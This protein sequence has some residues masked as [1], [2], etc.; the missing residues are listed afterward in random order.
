MVGE[1]RGLNGY[2]D[3]VPKLQH[4]SERDS[5]VGQTTFAFHAADHVVQAWR[6]DHYAPT[7]GGSYWLE[8]DTMGCIYSRSTVWPG[9]VVIRTNNDSINELI[10]MAIG[11]AS[12]SGHFGIGD[13]WPL[14]E[15]IETVKFI[16]S[17]TLSE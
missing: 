6:D 7:D 5:L 14:D 9:F 10:T 13:P 1:A 15:R 8:L 3:T 12:R 2:V 4:H 17:D 11:A 16:V